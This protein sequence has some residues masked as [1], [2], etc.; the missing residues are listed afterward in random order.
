[1]ISL[2]VIMV[3][4]NHSDPIARLLL[5]HLLPNLAKEGYDT[6]CLEMHRNVPPYKIIQRMDDQIDKIEKERDCVQIF[7]KGR[8]VTQQISDLRF[9]SL[10]S[11]RMK[12][13]NAMHFCVIKLF[14]SL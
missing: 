3:F 9:E 2:P 10:V 11:L 7:L 13:I 8:G 12:I 14:V 5:S 4:E 6:L 1:M